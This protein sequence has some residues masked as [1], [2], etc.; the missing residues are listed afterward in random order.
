MKNAKLKLTTWQAMVT[1]LVKYG[2]AATRCIH[3]PAFLSVCSLSVSENE[4]RCLAQ[5]R[6]QQQQV[7]QRAASS[8]VQKQQ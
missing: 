4:R 3:S 6:Q 7:Q 5:L 1:L 2:N 8:A